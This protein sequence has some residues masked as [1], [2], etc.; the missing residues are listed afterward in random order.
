MEDA[1]IGIDKY[2]APVLG[3]LLALIPGANELELNGSYLCP[4]CSESWKKE[5]GASLSAGGGLLPNEG[6]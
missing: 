3:P 1:T 5:R 2:M 4:K 6:T